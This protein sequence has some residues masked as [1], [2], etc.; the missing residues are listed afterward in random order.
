MSSRC[1]NIHKR[2]CD[3]LLSLSS[4]ALTVTMHAMWEL[5]Q[6]EFLWLMIWVFFCKVRMLLKDE[7]AESAHKSRGIHF[8]C[9]KKS[10]YL[11]S[12]V[13]YLTTTEECTWKN[14]VRFFSGQG[15]QS[16]K[17]ILRFPH[18]VQINVLWCFPD[19]IS[20]ENENLWYTKLFN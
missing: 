18:T 13:I 19:L 17:Q 3:T 20:T 5:S 7:T 16:Q 6:E 2:A 10:Q 9:R 11:L 12:L 8:L 14:A 1:T 4:H 15:P